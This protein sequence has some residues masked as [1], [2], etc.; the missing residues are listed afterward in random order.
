MTI[1]RI[2]TI[3]FTA[4]LLIACKQQTPISTT[5]E[6]KPVLSNRDTIPGL[7]EIVNA[8]A[9]GNSVESSH[10]GKQWKRYEQLKKLATDAE[11]VTL[12]DHKNPAVRCY[13]FRALAAKQSDQT[14]KVLVKHLNDASVVST[15][16]G[17]IV[18][19]QFVGD[20]FIYVVNPDYAEDGV[21]KLHTKEREIL[22]SILLNDKSI[23]LRAKYRAIARLAPTAENYARIRKLVKSD[24]NGI[25]LGILAKYHKQTD[26]KL[27]ASFFKDDDTQYSALYAVREFPDDY[28]FPFVIKVFEH[29]WKQEL[30][31]YGKWSICY[32]ALTKFPRPETIALFERTTASTDEFRYQTLCK[33]LLI[34]ITKYPNELY[35][36]FKA[37]IKLDSFYMDEVKEELENGE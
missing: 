37:K 19:D 29:E 28:F 25:A 22:D 23:R 11:L 15:Q 18:M 30:Y 9:K 3:L 34:A 12:T 5:V 14:F 36:P 31:D 10:F 7:N 8:I 13:A 4:S 24:K 17:C 35:D 1:Q 27:I 26:K 20:Y 32:Q 16:S 2:L 6:Q 21:Y 33:Y